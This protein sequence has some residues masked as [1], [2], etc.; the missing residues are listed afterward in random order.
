[1]TLSRSLN[2]RR[3]RVELA[4]LRRL[5]PFVAEVEERGLPLREYLD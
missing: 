5:G 1:M 2:C 4:C 3:F